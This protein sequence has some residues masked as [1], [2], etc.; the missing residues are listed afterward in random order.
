MF[1]KYVCIGGLVLAVTTTIWLAGR[2]LTT[3]CRVEA[4]RDHDPLTIRATTVVVRPWSGNHN[5]YGIFKV[6]DH[7]KDKKHA[8]SIVTNSRYYCFLIDKRTELEHIDQVFAP[9]GH[10]ILQIYLPTRVALMLILAGHLGD[11]EAPSNWALTFV[12]RVPRMSIE[13]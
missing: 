4:Y 8:V 13:P 2:A 12:D 10:Y 3:D 11:L 1:L 9:Q 5:V 6:P 7:Y